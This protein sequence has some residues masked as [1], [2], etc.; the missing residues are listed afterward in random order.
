MRRMSVIKNYLKQL[1]T[2][3]LLKINIFFK[4]STDDLELKKFFSMINPVV[5]DKELIRIGDYSDGGYLI[6]DD[7]DGIEVCFSPGVST[8]ASFELELTNYKIKSSSR[9]IKY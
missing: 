5:T 4:R 1:L 8:E 3:A 6:P 9:F 7:L 2:E